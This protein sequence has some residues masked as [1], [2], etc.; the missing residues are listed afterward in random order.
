MPKKVMRPSSNTLVIATDAKDDSGNHLRQRR[1]Q[2]KA[3][4]R[5]AT[6]V[7]TLVLGAFIASWLPFFR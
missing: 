6:L 3:K 5:Q 4:E 7:L 2:L 1:R